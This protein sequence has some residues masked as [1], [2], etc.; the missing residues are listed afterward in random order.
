VRCK[1]ARLFVLGIEVEEDATR[2]GRE[3]KDGW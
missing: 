1:T 2:E 3:E